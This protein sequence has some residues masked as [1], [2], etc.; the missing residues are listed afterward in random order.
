MPE[1]PMPELVRCKPCGYVC[2][3]DAL[4]GVCPACGVGVKAFEPYEDRVAA[5][6]RFILSLDLHPIIVHAPQ[7]FASILPGLVL[8]AVLFPE[9]YPE[10][11]E[12]VI[13][14]TALILPPSVAGAILSGLIDGK[15]RFKRLKSP[16]IV[17]KLFAGAG[18]LAVSITT[19]AT[20]LLGG[21]TA[22]TRPFLIGLSLTSFVCAVLLGRAGG[23]L[24]GP[25]LP[26]H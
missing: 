24:M 21:F 23:R 10:K 18:L 11:L 9:L 20:I 13:Y 17:Q 16:L 14:F 15:A 26:G 5:K 2:R 6:R 12:A 3:K 7:T 19:A 22:G 1:T 8:A 25:I 4:R